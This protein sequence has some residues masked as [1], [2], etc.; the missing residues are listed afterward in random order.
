MGKF[1]V[2]LYLPSKMIKLRVN[3]SVDSII[4]HLKYPCRCF[5]TVCHI[6]FTSLML[7]SFVFAPCLEIMKQ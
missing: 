5:I 3:D 4:T 7:N 1:L 2:V 6:F